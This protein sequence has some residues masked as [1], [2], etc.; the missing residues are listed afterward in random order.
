M[1]GW[2]RSVDVGWWM[3]DGGC[4]WWDGGAHEVV[5]FTRSIAEPAAP[6][7]YARA[8]ARSKNSSGTPF[9]RRR[10]DP[11]R[12]FLNAVEKL[13]GREMWMDEL[14]VDGFSLIRRMKGLCSG[15]SCVYV[16]Y[17][18]SF[19]IA[20]V[21]ELRVTRNFLEKEIFAPNYPS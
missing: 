9:H 6:P 4:R 1:V 14:N 13:R 18:V 21:R 11:S 12:S 17:I 5:D 15:W 8:Q 10:R 16:E 19:E 7:P 3:L 20:T 2:E